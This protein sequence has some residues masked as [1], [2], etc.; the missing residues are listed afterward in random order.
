MMIPTRSKI[1]R[2]SRETGYRMQ[3]LNWITRVIPHD[4]P[5]YRQRYGYQN[6]TQN[7][8]DVYLQEILSQL[9]RGICTTGS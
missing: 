6:I 3:P 8:R 9:D 1:R 4:Q 7:I 5:K 2:E